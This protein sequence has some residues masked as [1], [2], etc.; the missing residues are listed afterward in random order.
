MFDR[1]EDFDY[2]DSPPEDYVLDTEPDYGDPEP[3]LDYMTEFDTAMAS[4]GWG[5]DEDYG[6][7]GGDDDWGGD[8]GE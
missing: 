7:F 3:D 1:D 4:A 5:T 6:Y 2:I 8:W